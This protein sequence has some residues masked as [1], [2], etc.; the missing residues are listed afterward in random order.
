MG[1]EN[2]D[3]KAK[4]EAEMK[5]NL[6]KAL[7]GGDEKEIAEALTKFANSIQEKIIAE[8]KKAVNEDLTD[9]QAMAARGLKPLTKEEMTYYNEVIQ[10]QGF[11]GVEKLVPATVIDRVFEDLVRDHELLQNIE[12]VNTTGITEWILKKGDIPT[13]WWGRLPSEIKEILDEGFE[14]V[15]TELF[16]LSA[17]LPVAKA[18]LDLGP[19]WLDKY[20]RTVLTEAMAIGLEDA[21]IRGTG[22]EQPIGMMKDLAG[23][24]VDGVY[25]DKT[26]T[27]LTDLSPK[28]LGQHVM[29]PLTK[30]GKRKVN[31]VLFVVNPLDYWEK[32]FPETTILTQNGTYV[33]GVLPIPA[34]VIQSVSVPQG[35]LIAGLGKDY[36]LGV[37]SSRKIEYSDEVRFI[38]D[39][40]VY[41]T[42][43]YA[44]GRPKDNDSF[45]VFD[46]TN[47]GVETPTP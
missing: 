15:N 11:D 43:Q 37:G 24:V 31:Q 9:Q 21:I 38:E 29:A 5:E 32:I 19:V 45:L 47:L 41:V 22:K 33:Y 6:L 13:A 3:R 25:P 44:N 27:A 34:K 46:I 30:N 12:F 8:A 14:K 26:A 17:F 28:S 40:R 4:N 1:I 36:F 2:L 35:R 18:M 42:K 10:G 20:V 23:A 7:N 16:K 39:E